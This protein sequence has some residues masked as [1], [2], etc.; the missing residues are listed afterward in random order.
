M[1]DERQP[2]EETPEARDSIPGILASSGAG[3][4]LA[5]VAM[6]VIR[7]RLWWPV[8]AVWGAAVAALVA[9][10]VLRPRDVLVF[11]RGRGVRYG[12][13]TA[14]LV[15][16][17]LVLAVF[18]SYLGNR[19]HKRFDLTR[20]QVNTLSP[21]TT[22]ILRGLKQ[23]VEIAAFYSAGQPGYQEMQDL[24]QE[25]EYASGR[26][27]AQVIDPETSPGLARQYGVTTYSAIIVEAGGEKEEFYAASEQEITRAILKLTRPEKKKIYFVQGHGEHDLDSYDPDGYSTAQAALAA[28]NYET[29]KLPLAGAGEIP[30]D[31]DVLVIAGPTAEFDPREAD[32]VKAYLDAGGK[33]L[34]MTDPDG[35]GVSLAGL[36]EPWGLEPADDVVVEPEF[37]FFGDAQSV[38]VVD[39]GYHDIT[40]PFVKGRAL[41]AVFILVRA[42]ERVEQPSPDVNVQDL[43]RTSGESWLE[44]SFTGTISRSRGEERGPF[45]IAAVVSSGP[46]PGTGAE[47]SE[48]PRTR[49]VV[50]GDSD[51]AANG[52]IAN[53]VNKDLFL[54]SV[55]WLAESEELV[56]IQPKEPEQKPVLLTQTQQRLVL[57][58]ALIAMPLAPVVV[59]AVVWWRRR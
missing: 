20:T 6:L 24:L 34:I 53:G 17:A 40:R 30:A 28:L 25:Y 37:N 56:S 33:A 45:T 58:I 41:L 2:E 48:Q 51:F 47:D 8:Y 3:L 13:N 43:L 57:F 38:T 12:S 10:A 42:L 1:S 7:Q 26:V 49:L 35:Q 21:Q 14:V 54:N 44:T 16:L 39:F 36:L 23:T 9:A 31:C 22:K 19:H 32:A 27:K 15:I 11:L 18:A 5:G 55:G 29:Q 50:Y 46:P 4:L 59:G 52:I